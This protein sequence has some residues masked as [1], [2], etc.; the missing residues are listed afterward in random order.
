MFQQVPGICLQVSWNWLF[1]QFPSVVPDNHDDRYDYGDD[2]AD[3]DGE[4]HDHDNN[5]INEDYK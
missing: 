3:G 2:C 4:D 5:L 1:W